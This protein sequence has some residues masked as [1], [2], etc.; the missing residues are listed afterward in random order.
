LSTSNNQPQPKSVYKHQ[1]SPLF[2]LPTPSPINRAS[3][4]PTRLP[5]RSRS[6]S[7]QSSQTDS[8]LNSKKPLVDGS[9]RYVNSRHGFEAQRYSSPNWLHID[10]LTKEVCQSHEK[11]FLE[12]LYK[13][14]QNER[15]LHSIYTS[16]Y[17]SKRFHD[18]LQSYKQG[19]LTHAEWAKQNYQL[20]CLKNF[21]IQASEREQHHIDVYDQNLREK[22][23]QSAFNEWK[24]VK[25]EKN[26][27]RRRSRLNTPTSQRAT[28]V[29]SALSN[30]SCTVPV[31]NSIDNHNRMSISTSPDT[32]PPAL[33][34]YQPN[35]LS[36]NTLPM[37]DEQR[38]SL[39]SMLKRVVGLAEPLP[40][41]S[42]T[43]KRQS[44][45]ITHLSTDSGFE[46]GVG[47]D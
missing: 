18:L 19:Y 40:S 29:S 21:Y 47:R 17:Y 3:P 38:W 33:S 32:E 36:T 24:E 34:I 12:M 37:L 41:L 13:K 8:A 9:I 4:K 39:K 11:T 30:A 22:R 42:Q 15:L 14:E 43:I 7:I 46:S 28:D 2:R 26:H 20:S 16:E 1:A 27:E 5:N 44:S 10:L 25:D 45:S 31:L 23:A 35:I 6:Q